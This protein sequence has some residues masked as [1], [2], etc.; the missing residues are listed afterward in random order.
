MFLSRITP[1]LRL[2]I[3]ALIIALVLGFPRWLLNFRFGNRI[4]SAQD[5]PARDAAV[6]LGAGLRRDGRPTTVLADRVATAVSLYQQGKVD[7]LLMSGSVQPGRDEPA[8]MRA[9]A[10][11][12]GVP[13][14][15][16]LEDPQGNRTYDSCV[17]ARTV[18]NIRNALIVT[19]RFHLPR[20]LALCDANDID[21]A[22]VS[23][24]RRL[25]RA[26]FFWD[27]REIPASYRALWDVYV[28]SPDPV[29]PQPNACMQSPEEGNLDGS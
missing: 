29:S 10:I 1:L 2:L 6:V 24:D 11:E 14:D 22:G 16:I 8:A 12:L 3:A 5:A 28:N 20:A 26:S 17:R 18:Y 15:S 7:R 27:I 25:Y 13:G 19:Q 4:Y 21:A 23:A 9:L